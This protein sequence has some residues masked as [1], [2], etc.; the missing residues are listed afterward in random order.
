MNSY[1]FE[2]QHW[3]VEPE[4]LADEGV[5]SPLINNF[6]ELLPLYKHLEGLWIFRSPSKGLGAMRHPMQVR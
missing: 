5:L 2:H 1:F 3:N 4:G 6:E